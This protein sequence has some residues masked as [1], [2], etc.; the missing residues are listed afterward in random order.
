[1]KNIVKRELREKAKNHKTTMGVLSVTNTTNGKQYVQGSLHLEALVNKMKFLLNGGLFT[2]ALLQK[3]WKELGSDAFIF[4]FEIIV[5]EQDNP[6][7][8]YRQEI[9]KAEKAFIAEATSE[10]Y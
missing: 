3:D 10:L 8:N 6:Y 1:M 4:E 7:I 9:S 5:P 2:N